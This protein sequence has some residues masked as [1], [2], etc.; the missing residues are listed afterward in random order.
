M[1]E[2]VAASALAISVGAN[3]PYIFDIIKGRAKPERISWLLWTLLG[4][5]YYFSAM[6]ADGAT[7]FTLGELI[8]PVVIFI[9]ALKFGVGGKSRFDIYALVIALVAFGLLFVFDG[10]LIGLLLALFIDG[11][12]AVLTIRKLRVDPSSESRIFWALGA[13]AATLALLSLQTYTIE[14]MLFP[15][16]VLAFSSLVVIISAP[17]KSKHPKELNQ[18]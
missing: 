18:L 15:A 8:G 2:L 17:Q 13:T 12:G 6:F 5:T 4:L 9:L 10:V 1:K 16:Y 7:L 14:T 11:I 3:I